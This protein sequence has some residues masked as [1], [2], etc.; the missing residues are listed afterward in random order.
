MTTSE[1]AV[2]WPWEGAT[3]VWDFVMVA[4]VILF[5][6]ACIAYVRGCERL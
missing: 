3:R 1:H 5:F 6:V 4:T 2:M